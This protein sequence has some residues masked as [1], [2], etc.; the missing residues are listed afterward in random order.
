MDE[1]S[2][3]CYLEIQY[4]TFD[5]FLLPGLL[6]DTLVVWGGEFGRTIYSQGVLAENNY[7]R[8]HHRRCFTIFMAGAGIQPGITYGATDDYCYKIT[9]NPGHVHDLPATMLNLLGVDH[10]RLTYKF[11]GR[12]FRL[13]DVHGKLVKGI[14]S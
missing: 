4:S 8:D 3:I 2:L 5:P 7:G 13:T 11:Q 6:E 9:E 10:E 1:A 12:R 14:R